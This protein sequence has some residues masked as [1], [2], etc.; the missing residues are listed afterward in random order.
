MYYTTLLKQAQVQEYFLDEWPFRLGHF[1]R[2]EQNIGKTVQGIYWLGLK[3]I[4][5]KDNICFIHLTIETLR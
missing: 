1:W 2:T 3:K 5:N 4:V